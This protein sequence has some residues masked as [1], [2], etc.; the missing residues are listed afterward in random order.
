MVSPN[1]MVLTALAA[2]ELCR[3]PGTEK[4]RNKTRRMASCS[5][6][7][8]F[9]GSS[10]LGECLQGLTSKKWNSLGRSVV[11]KVGRL[12]RVQLSRAERLVKEC[13]P[14]QTICATRLD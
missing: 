6:K 13:L 1:E 5:G 3:C 8:G 12:H 4:S 9:R 7:L 11:A 2:R 14:P 10:L